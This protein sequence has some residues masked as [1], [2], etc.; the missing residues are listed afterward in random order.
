[1]LVNLYS[2]PVYK[3]KLPEHEQVQ[4]DFADI[5]DALNSKRF[6]KLA[7]I[8]KILQDLPIR[9]QISIIVTDEVVELHPGGTRL[10]L[11]DYY[12]DP[13]PVFVYSKVPLD[14]LTKANREN[15]KILNKKSSVQHFNDVITI[16]P[17]TET[18]GPSEYS[19]YNSKQYRKTEDKVIVPCD[20]F[21]NF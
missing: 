9:N 1:M 5:L 21:L 10:T 2:I 3:I 6:M 12:T 15:I 7:S 14:I 19:N 18:Y 16:T 11:K 20:I 13:V 17:P 8:V 4:K